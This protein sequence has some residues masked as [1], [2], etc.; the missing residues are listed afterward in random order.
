[1]PAALARFARDGGKFIRIVTGLGNGLEDG[2]KVFVRIRIPAH[3]GMGGLHIHQ[4]AAHARDFLRRIG[5]YAG[6]IV[7]RHAGDMQ[8]SCGWR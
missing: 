7:A 8:L 1:M 2:A 3:A 5:D 6:A 4:N